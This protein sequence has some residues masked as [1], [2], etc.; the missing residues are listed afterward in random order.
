V[1]VDDDGFQST[2]DNN[3][4]IFI[5]HERDT[6][7]F[8]GKIEQDYRFLV[9]LFKG[10]GRQIEARMYLDDPWVVSVT[11]PIDWDGAEADVL[12]YLQERFNTIRQLGGPDGYRTIWEKCSS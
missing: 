5:T 11:A 9:Y 7:V 1:P 2:D 3:L 8:D 10:Q 6:I 4:P 12:A